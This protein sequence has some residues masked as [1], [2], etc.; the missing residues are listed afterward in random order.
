[1]NVMR[2]GEDTDAATAQCVLDALRQCTDTVRAPC[3]YACNNTCT[4][5]V[6]FAHN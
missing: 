5:A 6:A 1:M 3:M 2:H 4:L